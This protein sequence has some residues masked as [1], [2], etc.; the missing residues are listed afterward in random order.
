MIAAG[1]RGPR[2]TMT[3][4]AGQSH[5]YPFAAV[6]GQGERWPRADDIVSPLASTKSPLGLSR[7]LKAAALLHTTMALS[8]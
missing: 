6:Y 7:L 2:I 1:R 8:P 4:E 3:A 5:E